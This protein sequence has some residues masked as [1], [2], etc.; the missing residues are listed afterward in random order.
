MLVA[1]TTCS[2][3]SDTQR[4]DCSRVMAAVRERS[5]LS[6]SDSETSYCVPQTSGNRNSAPYHVSSTNLPWGVPHGAQTQ[7]A[8]YFNRCELAQPMMPCVPLPTFGLSTVTPQIDSPMSASTPKQKSS[9]SVKSVLSSAN[10]RASNPSFLSSLMAMQVTGPVGQKCERVTS[11]VSKSRSDS[12]MGYN[13]AFGVVDRNPF[14]GYLPNWQIGIPV[15][16]YVGVT[17]GYYRSPFGS[18]MSH[19]MAAASPLMSSVDKTHPVVQYQDG[20]LD[21]SCPVV[22]VEPMLGA[23]SSKRDSIDNRHPSQVCNNDIVRDVSLST[24]M[25]VSSDQRTFCTNN[26]ASVP[27]YL[28]DSNGK[29]THLYSPAAATFKCPSSSCSVPSCVS[30]VTPGDAASVTSVHVTAVT[31]SAFRPVTSTVSPG[32]NPLSLQPPIGASVRM[33][34]MLV[35]D[36]RMLQMEF[37]ELSARESSGVA[38]ATGRRLS[39]P[40]LQKLYR[41]SVDRTETQRFQTLRG[42]MSE[43]QRELVHSHYDQQ[44]LLLLKD[45]RCMLHGEFVARPSPH[46]ASN[47]TVQLPPIVSVAPVSNN[48]NITTQPYIDGHNTIRSYPESSSPDC[49]IGKGT[50]RKYLNQDAVCVLSEWYERHFDHPYPEDDDVDTLASRAEISASQVKKWMAN[51]RV[52]SCNTLAFNGSIHPKKLQ[53]L[54]QLKDCPPAPPMEPCTESLASPPEKCGNSKRMLNPSAVSFMNRW[55]YERQSYPYP[56]EDEKRCIAGA[57]GITTAQ[58]TCWFANKRNRSHNTRKM[59]AAHMLHK[60]NRKLEL[61]NTMQ[62]NRLSSA[63][64]CDGVSP[65]DVVACQTLTQ[66]N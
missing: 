32:P 59:S 14:G 39:V 13:S 7:I 24:H 48:Q 5:L 37:L 66:V 19:K 15:R 55:Y 57:T 3:T 61:Y 30:P 31:K 43:T 56:T 17:P 38:T 62:R 40:Q 45:V 46:S 10:R 12:V 34:E 51:K 11:P 64:T 28:L 1:I 50:K 27:S 53:K 2:T 8:G 42:S 33:K 41:E 58:V 52:R 6:G 22:K 35:Y 36:N 54:L 65:R 49:Y 20:P 60:L 29:R 26:S 18:E 23:K 47:V 44:R 16:H 21:L 63:A 4:S 25:S 9:N